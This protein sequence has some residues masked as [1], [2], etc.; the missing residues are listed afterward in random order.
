MKIAG[1]KV[2]DARKPLLLEITSRDVANSSRKDP[3][4]C[5]AAVA[6]KRQEH[7]KDVRVH[8]SHTYVDVGDKFIRY[9]T[10]NRMRTEIVAFDRGVQFEPGQY[11]LRP[12]QPSHKLGARDLRKKRPPSIHKGNKKRKW[13]TPSGVRASAHS[14]LFK[15]VVT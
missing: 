2:V 9:V 3:N 10:P 11:N 14:N 4:N 7:V 1:K 13:H 6:C 15:K 12:P 5:A 8:L